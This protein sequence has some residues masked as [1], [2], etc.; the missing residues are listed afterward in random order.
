MAYTSRQ[1]IGMGYGGYAGWGDAGANAD[2]M[3]TGGSGKK[4]SPSSP[5]GASA[6]TT[7]YA[8]IARR[9]LELQREATRPAIEQLT[10]SKE[11]ITQAYGEQK[12][13][14]EAYRSPLK[15]KYDTLLKSI[16]G[17]Q[18]TATSR[19][20]GRRGIPLSSGAFDQ[21]L[22][23]QTQ[24]QRERIGAESNLA[25]ADLERLI[26]GIGVSKQGQL[27]AVDQAIAQLQAGG[28]SSAITQAMQLLQNQ[29]SQASS[30][31]EQAWKEKVYKETTLPQSRATVAKAY[32]DA[33]SGNEET[34]TLSDIFNPKASPSMS[35]QQTTYR[36]PP[37]SPARDGIEQ[38]YPKGSGVIWT[39]KGGRWT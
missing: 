25:Q 5:T 27:S 32:K 35:T 28:S 12:A 8:S 9:Q 38:E 36:S 3:A 2:F 31:A 39:S 4:T 23:E 26:S 13:G 19:E 20:F 18:S 22:L 24:P 16:V 30:A 14:L 7:D 37:S 15:E 17:E 33:S 1:L 21:A 6:P 29:Q 11:G 34:M 10:S